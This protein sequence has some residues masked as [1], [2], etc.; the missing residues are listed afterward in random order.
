[1]INDYIRD[2]VTNKIKE[3]TATFDNTKQMII[4]KRTLL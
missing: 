2:K 4:C 3:R 1:M